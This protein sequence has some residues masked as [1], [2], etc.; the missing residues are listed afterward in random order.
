MNEIKNLLKAQQELKKAQ[1]NIPQ[2]IREAAEKLSEK[3]GMD[4]YGALEIIDMIPL[5]VAQTRK[6]KRVAKRGEG[7]HGGRINPENAQDIKNRILRS[8]GD[9]RNLYVAALA[10]FEQKND[11]VA[12]K[13]LKALGIDNYRSLLRNKRRLT[14]CLP[15][16]YTLQSSSHGYRA[17]NIQEALA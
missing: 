2:N 10:L 4:Y 15:V 1:E 3:S 12:G 13:E 9:K 16:G 8:K 11:W 17:Y 6:T 7:C 5:A 14:A